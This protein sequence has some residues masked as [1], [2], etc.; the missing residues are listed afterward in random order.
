ML[1]EPFPAERGKTLS[2]LS[3]HYRNETPRGSKAAVE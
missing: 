1:A 3:E 2:D